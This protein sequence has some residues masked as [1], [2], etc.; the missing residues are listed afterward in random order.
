MNKII[1]MFILCMVAGKL[2]GQSYSCEILPYNTFQNNDKIKGKYLYIYSSADNH[3][4]DS[5]FIDPFIVKKTIFHI[6]DS[7]LFIVNF[8]YPERYENYTEYLFYKYMIRSNKI[9]LQDFFETNSS[10]R[11]FPDLES[12]QLLF[13]EKTLFLIKENFVKIGLSVDKITKAN[14]VSILKFCQNIK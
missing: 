5:I 6:K 2:T 12:M 9:F 7:F 14:I 10:L 11:G 8:Q 4:I 3:K 1:L 13:D